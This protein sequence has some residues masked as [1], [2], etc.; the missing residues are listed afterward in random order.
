MK[1]ELA[2]ETPLKMSQSTE[3]IEAL[4][5]FKQIDKEI[6]SQRSSSDLIEAQENEVSIIQSQSN[7]QN[8]ESLDLNESL[9]FLVTKFTSQAFDDQIISQEENLVFCDNSVDSNL[10]QSHERF[11]IEE[12]LLVKH[13]HFH[14]DSQNHYSSKEQLSSE[15]SL[16]N[17]VHN[18]NVDQYSKK[19]NDLTSIENK[20]P[21]HI[22]KLT[23][24]SDS[25]NASRSPKSERSRQRKLTHSL[26]DNHKIK[27]PSNKPPIQLAYCTRNNLRNGSRS[28]IQIISSPS[29]NDI[30]SNDDANTREV[31]V[32]TQ[33]LMEKNVLRIPSLST[34]I[35]E[36]EQKSFPTNVISTSNSNSSSLNELSL[37]GSTLFSNTSSRHLK[38]NTKS[39]FTSISTE[40]SV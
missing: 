33:S 35:S 22:L 27:H 34:I 32:D 4:V 28:P 5:I 21:N 30:T 9:P 37:N 29:Y 19:N 2:N 17:N 15:F 1:T 13:S 18:Q 36:S 11:R 3:D 39:I 10:N 20:I 14:S 40:T 16:S 6:S 12:H 25:T 26:S 24:K 7:N 31:D 8:K 23:S 38:N